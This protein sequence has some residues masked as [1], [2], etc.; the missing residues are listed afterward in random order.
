LTEESKTLATVEPE[1]EKAAGATAIINPKAEFAEQ[2]RRDGY[3]N[4]TIKQCA[5]YLSLF[6]KKGI[7]ILRPEEVKTFIAD[8]KWQ[9]H[10]KATAVTMYGVFASYMRLQWVPLRYKYDQK[11]PFIP[12]EKEIDDL[13][14]G[15]GKKTSPLLRLLKETGARITEALRIKWTDLDLVKGTVAINNPEKNSL[16]RNLKISPALTAMLNTLPRESDYVINRSRNTVE[17][18]YQHQRNKLARKLGN[19]RLKQIHLHT[20][21]H[22]FATMMYART[23]KIVGVQQALGHKSLLNTQLYPHLIDF[24]SDEYTV[25]VAENLEEAKKLLEVGYDYITEMEG[26]KLFRK[27]K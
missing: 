13:I 24:D 22:F 15:S 3:S 5:H 4:D 6:E 1:R 8:Q 16:P 27:R 7:R 9:T 14:A 20:F 10:S 12:T 19:P 17:S 21:R 23:L 26:Q 2:L 11:I 18:T 25:Q